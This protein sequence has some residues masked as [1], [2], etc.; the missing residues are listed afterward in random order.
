MKNFL[1]VVLAGALPLGASANLFFDNF[2]TDSTAN[3]SFFSSIAA[4]TANDGVGGEANVFFD[5]STVGIASAPNSVGGTTRGMKV[6]AN[7]STG[8]FSGMS[9]SPTG[10]SFTGDYIMTMDVWQNYNGPAPAGGSGS[11]QL[12]MAGIGTAGASAQFQGAG[13]DGRIFGA[14]G[15]GGSANDYRA[16]NNVGAPLA[17]TSGAYAAGNTAGVTNN[18]NAYYSGF[19]GTIPGAQTALFPQ[20]TGAPA[21]GV[22]AFK[23]RQWRITKS[24]DTVTWEIVDNNVPTLIATMAYGTPGGTNIAIGQSDINATSSTDPNAGALLFGLVDNVQVTAV[25]EPATMVV[26]G[27][28]AAAVLRRRKKS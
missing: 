19:Q 8:V 11:T 21:V 27:L 3:W 28:G 5:Y 1:L 12:T 26:L 17:D 14:T 6:Q 24:G 23:W 4:D 7:L 20:Q 10:Q 25:P 13:L 9:M 18:S 16:Y 2:D 15:D 22:Q